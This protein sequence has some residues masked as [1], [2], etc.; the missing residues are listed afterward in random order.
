MFG[1]TEVYS[2]PDSFV[3]VKYSIKRRKVKGFKRNEI[4]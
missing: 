1:A 2:G 3:E 4:Q